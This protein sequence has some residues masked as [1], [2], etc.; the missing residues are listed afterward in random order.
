MKFIVNQ[1]LTAGIFGA[2]LLVSNTGAQSFVG[3]TLFAPHNS[4]NTY[5]INNSN[6][7]VKTWT[8][9]IAGGY[10]YYLLPDGNLM[11][12]ANSSGSSL[13]GG[14][15]TGIVQK[16]DKNN[17]VLWSYTYSTSTYRT[18]HDICPMA[19]GNVLLIAWEVKT[20]A[21]A[22]QAGLN[23]SAVIWPDH[24]IEV[25]PVGTN[26][27]N[28][29]WQWHAW[30]HLI[31]DYNSSKDNYGVVADHP[32]L[33]DINVGSAGTGDWMHVNGL[34]YNPEWDQIVFSS[35]NLNEVYVIDHST[36]TAQA[37]THRGGRSG[38]GGDFLYR[39]GKPSNYRAPGAAVF[40][41]VHCATWIPQGLPGAG[42]IMA[43]NNRNGTGASMV[44]ELVP[45]ADTAGV[46]QWTPGTAYGPASP[47]WSYSASGFYSN[48]L[49]GCQRLPNGNTMLAE[50][51]T[52]NLWEVTASGATAWNYPRGGEIV[53]VL[54][55]APDYPGIQ[56]II[57][58]ELTAFTA[59]LQ[60][61]S[62]RLDWSTASETNNL[63]FEIEKKIAAGEFE[64]IG[65][66]AGA[67]TTT[68]PQTY[69]FL[70]NAIGAG[71]ITY[72]LK[73]IDMD[74]TYAYSDPLTIQIG[75]AEPSFTL[76]QNYPNPFNPNTTIAFSVAS[77]G[78]TELKVYNA[79]GE[80][81]Q[82]LFAQYAEAV[83][84]YRSTFS[85][86]GLPSGVYT[87]TLRREGSFTAKQMMLIK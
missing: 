2:V 11:R 17:A 56:A 82:T 8:H 22:V 84:E 23:H 58:V 66:V 74:G 27:G 7:I 86:A 51:T 28:I 63:R 72:R 20:A 40:N 78:W 61:N 33:L 45:P 25:Q 76:L 68:I 69:S 53:R 15:A 43:F 47:V 21:Q 18:H 48:H 37:A 38:K 1:M 60:G 34:S 29:V 65:T 49:G 10:S 55:Y 5:L 39:W 24:I 46:Y 4:K 57:P 3:Y 44:V 73:Q 85:G 87:Y 36:T 54:R 6:T 71:S 12:T 30:D 81:V 75:A 83:T 19:N 50:S 70:D 59:S 13:N 80:L 62:V 77:G 35:H 41:V 31:Q 26:G 67:G 16:V 79:V 52:G 42:H 14:G 32:E 64:A 9:A